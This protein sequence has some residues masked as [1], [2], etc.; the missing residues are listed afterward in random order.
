MYSGGPYYVQEGD[1]VELECKLLLENYPLELDNKPFVGWMK[2]SGVS[3]TSI[4]Q[5]F[6]NDK[7]TENVYLNASV[8]T[9]TMNASLLDQGA[10]YCY[11]GDD[12]ST[13][14]SNKT[15]INVEGEN[16]SLILVIV[17]AYTNTQSS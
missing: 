9:V 13:V 7:R 4:M 6:Y 5:L 14:Y 1:V 12:Y 17:K 16:K 2:S 10:Y 11:Y 8:F 15:G 3:N